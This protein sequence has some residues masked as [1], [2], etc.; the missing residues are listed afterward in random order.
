MDVLYF[1]ILCCLGLGLGM[2]VGF[3]LLNDCLLARVCLL[4]RS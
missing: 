3:E 4:H 1:C 2:E